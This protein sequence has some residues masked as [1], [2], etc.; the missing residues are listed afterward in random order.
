MQCMK[1]LIFHQNIA[2]VYLRRKTALKKDLYQLNI[3]CL[4]PRD[5]QIILIST[6][7]ILMLKIQTIT[8]QLVAKGR[9]V[10]I[11]NNI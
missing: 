8:T 11:Q 1:Y 9:T 6:D 2:S 4:F 5:Q 3:V 7:F 10:S